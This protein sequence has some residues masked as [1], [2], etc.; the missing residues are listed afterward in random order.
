MDRNEFVNQVLLRLDQSKVFLDKSG[1]KMK[2]NLDGVHIASDGVSVT[3]D[4]AYIKF[5]SVLNQLILVDLVRN[6]TYIHEY[7]QDEVKIEITPDMFHIKM[8]IS[9]LK[10]ISLEALLRVL[11]A[12]QIPD[13]K[14]ELNRI[15]IDI[16][17]CNGI[18]Y[19]T[20]DG[21]R[22]VWGEVWNEH[23]LRIGK[24]VIIYDGLIIDIISNSYFITFEKGIMSIML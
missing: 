10:P 7:A 19:S 4:N 17:K 1:L 6:E 23:E 16:T 9:Q 13:A 18:Q 20:D 12:L 24:N 21:L 15:D 22:I 5:S 11:E 2:S 14:R 3:I 8:K